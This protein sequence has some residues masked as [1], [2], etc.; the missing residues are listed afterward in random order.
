MKYMVEM[1][2]EVAKIADIKKKIMVDPPNTR[3]Y[4]QTMWNLYKNVS[5]LNDDYYEEKKL[6]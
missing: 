1:W 4:E 6:I 5:V 3:K 2:D